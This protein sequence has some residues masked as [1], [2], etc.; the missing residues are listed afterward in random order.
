[1]KLVLSPPQACRTVAA[2]ERL[3]YFES[4][5]IF[6]RKNFLAHYKRGERNGLGRREKRPKSNR[7]EGERKQKIREMGETG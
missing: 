3:E 7:D 4:L 1:M 2:L 5:K 6:C